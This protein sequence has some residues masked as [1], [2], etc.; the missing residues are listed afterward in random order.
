[1]GATV[2]E[3]S[4]AVLDVDPGDLTWF[5]KIL[6]LLFLPFA[7]E[8]LAIILGGYIIVNDLMPVALVALC[9]YVGMVASD[10]ALYGLGAAARYVPWLK[11]YAV[12]D[13]VRYLGDTLKRNVF[14]VVAVCR[15]IPGIV[16]VAF[17]A[18]GWARVSLA[19]FTAATLIVSALYLPLMLYLV[20]TFGDALEDHFGLWAW[21]ILFVSLAATALVRKRVFALVKTGNGEE[22]AS[23]PA[24]VYGHHGMPELTLGDRKLAVAERIPPMLF[25][26]PLILSWIGFGLR[27][28]SFTL[29][30][31]AN[32]KIFTGGM[33]GESKSDYLLDIG[34]KERAF[35]A[36]FALIT[37]GVGAASADH[38][39]ARAVAAMA[40]RGIEYPL[41]AKPD[42]GWHGHGVRLIADADSLRQYVAGFPAG[43][44][45]ILQRFVPYAGEA[46]VLYAR[47]PGEQR[48]RV[49]SLTFRY[50]PHVVGNGHESIRQL[51][52]KDARAR[53]KSKLHLG[54]D[55]TH[56]GLGESELAQIPAPG[57]VVQ[58]ALIGNQRAGALYR[59][60]RRFITAAMER[61]IDA[62]ACSMTEFHYGRFDLRFESVEALARGE[63]FS[64]V[65][66]NGIG[67]EA[68]DV[69]DPRL[70]VGEVYR[71][72]VDQQRLL[73]LIGRR[74]RD[75]G[76]VPTRF[77][78]FATSLFRQNRLI[79]QYPAST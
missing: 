64:I 41:I 50:F 16:F 48:G 54:G 56:Q 63:G 66:V 73:F 33:W 25:Y 26:F 35:V 55:A 71:R 31:A 52:G 19:R 24:V 11:R 38:D 78:E 37:R 32:P 44:N 59:D 53:W 20:I 13:R 65:E 77:R 14:S 69:W 21:P 17:V 46:A 51:I 2:L 58:I 47:L 36:D 60:G 68:I 23:E 34:D 7:H 76:F 10:F 39:T 27:H 45:I 6:S 62:I 28:R 3:L 40:G 8:D 67:G 70:P 5:A 72:L 4:A 79:K 75:R 57:E 9:L 74:N 61:Q 1:L 42:I 22:T 49:L 29:P 43:G 12:D 30:T 15:V 18:C